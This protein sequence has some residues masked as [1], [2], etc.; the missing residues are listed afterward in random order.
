MSRDECNAFEDL[1]WHQ[2][3]IDVRR[4]DDRAKVPGQKTMTLADFVPAL[5][6]ALS[7]TP[8]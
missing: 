6:Q 4:L 2:R 7:S 8:S 5:K 3:A 1:P